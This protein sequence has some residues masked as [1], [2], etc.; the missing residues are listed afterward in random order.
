MF[1]TKKKGRRNQSC[2]RSRRSPAGRMLIFRIL[3]RRMLAALHIPIWLE[4]HI[5]IKFPTKSNPPRQ[6]PLACNYTPVTWYHQSFVH[7]GP[8]YQMHHKNA[9]TIS[10]MTLTQ[11]P[12][13]PASISRRRIIAANRVEKSEHTI[14]LYAQHCNTVQ[15]YWNARIV[16]GA[17]APKVCVMVCTCACQHI[18]TG[19]PSERVHSSRCPYHL[20]R[21]DLWCCDWCLYAHQQSTS[22]ISKR[23]IRIG[24]WYCIHLARRIM[25]ARKGVRVHRSHHR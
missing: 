8:S 23:P 7:T 17:R 24:F 3:I 11:T 25:R 12:Q 22:W 4:T 19:G 20:H 1:E 2:P 15:H 18:M 9:T 16:T 13:P 5:P 10:A 14:I 6:I 21:V